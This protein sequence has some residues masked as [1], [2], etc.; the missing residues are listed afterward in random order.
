MRRKRK[1]PGLNNSS[2]ADISFILLSFFL[3]TTSMGADKGLQR[4]LPPQTDEKEKRNLLKIEIDAS[5]NITC[6]GKPMKK[7]ALTA[8][9]KEFVSN[10]E[11]SPTLP[12]KHKVDIPLLGGNISTTTEHLIAL[13]TN[14]NTSY[15]TYF[16]IQDRIIR[17]YTELRNELSLRKFGQPF[18]SLNSEQKEAVRQF[19][20]QRISEIEITQKGGE[21]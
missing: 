20:P 15:E 16:D 1:V 14:P 3:M 12:E 4:R 13:Q 2:I 17:G 10:K 19:Y 9:V 11:N 5:G 6:N 7:E 18:A 8:E 21:E